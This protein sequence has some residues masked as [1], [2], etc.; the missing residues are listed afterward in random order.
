MHE[1]GYV[2]MIHNRVRAVAEQNNAEAVADVYLDV[3]ELRDL[4]LEWIER[5][6]NYAGKG[7]ITEGA[8]IHINMIPGTVRCFNCGAI[9]P[10]GKGN[11]VTKCPTCGGEDLRMNTGKE[12]EVSRISLIAGECSE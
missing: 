8:Q 4:V 2:K 3:G 6:F 12:F 5:Y 11:Y 10:V 1:F 7:T 9:I